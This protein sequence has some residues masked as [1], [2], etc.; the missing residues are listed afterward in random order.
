MEL[1]YLKELFFF[2]KWANPGL[3]LFDFRLFNQTNTNFATNQCEKCPSSIQCWDSNQQPL[4]HELSPVTT[5]PG[6]PPTELFSLNALYS[7]RKSS[8]Q[9][10]AR[11]DNHFLY[12]SSTPFYWLKIGSPMLIDPYPSQQHAGLQEIY[13]GQEL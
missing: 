1:P 2:F 10:V 3:F 9:L 5:R 7:F 13:L 6:L 8:Y 12:L 4:K 11:M